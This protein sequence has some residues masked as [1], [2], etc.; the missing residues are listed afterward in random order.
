MSA[1]RLA[2]A[3]IGSRD[4]LESMMATQLIAAHN[5]ATEYY[6][7][8]MIREQTFEGRRENLSQA[9]T[10]SPTFASLLDVLRRR[11]A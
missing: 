4:E 9:N 8:A 5:A 7:R 1:T 11:H 6:R 10:L 2:L 3:G